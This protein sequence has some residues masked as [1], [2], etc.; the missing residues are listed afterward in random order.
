MTKTLPL[1][2]VVNAVLFA[3][4]AVGAFFVPQLLATPLEISLTTPT[5]LADFR[6]VYGGLS[7]GIAFLSVFALRKPEF[8]LPVLWLLTFCM[9]GLILGRLISTVM[10]GPGS[11]VI[12]AQLGLELFSAAWGFALIRAHQPTSRTS[13]P[14]GV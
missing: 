14:L 9:D 3:A 7:F 13:A 4:F 5:A 12:F 6:A 2:F 1:Y 11:V 8:Q 10:S